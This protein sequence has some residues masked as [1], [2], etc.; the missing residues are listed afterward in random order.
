MAREKHVTGCQPLTGLVIPVGHGKPLEELFREK[1]AHQPNIWVARHSVPDMILLRHLLALPH[2]PELPDLEAVPDDSVRALLD[3]VDPGHIQV[4]RVDSH[5]HSEATDGDLINEPAVERHLIA[6]HIHHAVGKQH[7][8][9]ELGCGSLQL[10]GHIHIGR[11]VGGIDLI[12]AAD[13]SLNGPAAMQAKPELD[14]EVLY[15]ELEPGVLPVHREDARLVDLCD[16]LNVGHQRH[17]RQLGLLFGLV[18]CQ[19][20]HDQEGVA[21]VSIR[22]PMKV[23]NASMNNLPNLVDKK[24]DLLFENLRRRHEVPNVAKADDGFHLRARNHGVHTR[25]SAHLHVLADHF[26]PGFPK[27]Q[28]QK[29]P[30]LDD[31]L[32]Q[33]DRFHWLLVLL[34]MAILVE[35]LP[36]TAHLLQLLA[37]ACLVNLLPPELQIAKTHGLQRVVL[38][39]LHF[40]DHPLNRVQQQLI[41]VL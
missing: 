18:A 12:L 37:K 27:T 32:L 33:H 30:Q 31:G 3:H 9:L 24:H 19:P 16:D 23:V 1:L 21:N 4:H 36:R 26:C 40:F 2:L 8:D 39:G 5:R 20:P 28:G 22:R 11:Q 34:G 10:G 15:A 13:C 6:A 14:P 35:D 29:A 38:D 7:P 17:V 25:C 41:G